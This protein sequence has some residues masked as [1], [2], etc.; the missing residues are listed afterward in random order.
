M[1]KYLNLR[2]VETHLWVKV[3]LLPIK[4]RIPKPEISAC[5]VCRHCCVYPVLQGMVL[6]QS[7]TNWKD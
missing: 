4:K 3:L 7:R 2:V 6:A 1:I 5:R